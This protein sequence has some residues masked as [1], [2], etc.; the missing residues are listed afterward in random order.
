MTTLSAERPILLWIGRFFAHDGYG[1]AARLHRAAVRE[2]GA[3]VVAVDIVSR[4]IVGSLPDGLVDVRVTPNGLTVRATDHRRPIVA[5]VHDRPDQYRRVVAAGRSQ[6]I[7]YSYWETTSVPPN[8]AAWMTSMDRIWVSSQFNADAFASA[9]VPSWMIDRVGHPI[10]HLACDVAM[11]R[12]ALRARWPESTVFLSI[13]S[14]AVGRRDTNLLFEAFAMAFDQDDDVALV[15]KVPEKGLEAVGVSLEQVMLSMAARSSGRWPNVYTI[16]AVLTREQLLRLHASV[17]CY[18]SCERGNGWD[19]P[20]FD[21]MTMGIPV[22]AANFGASTTFVDPVDSYVV[23]VSTRFTACDAAF[24]ERHSLYSGQYWPYVDPAAMAAELR[25]VHDAP[26]DRAKRGAAAA[27]R[28]THDYDPAAVA[29]EV[30]ALTSTARESDLRANTPAVVTISQNDDAWGRTTGGPT[31]ATNSRLQEAALAG[32]LS[33]QDF[34]HPR[35]PKD[36]WRAYKRATT[37]AQRHGKTLEGSALKTALSRP[38]SVPMTRPAHKLSAIVRARSAVA[39]ALTKLGDPEDLRDVAALVQNYEAVLGGA[40]SSLTPE[41]LEAMWVEVERYGLTR[42]PDADLARLRELRDRHSGRVFILGNGPSLLRCDLSRLADEYTFGVNKIYLL[43]DQISWRPTYYTLLDRKMGAAVGADI[44]QLDGTVK[45]VPERF[46]GVFP[47]GPSTYWYWTRPVGA[48]IDDQFEPDISLGIPSRATVLVTAIQQAFYLGFRTIILI[49]V[50]A[51]YTIPE[52]V[53]QS[54]PDRFGTGT[55]LH[56]TST[57]DD[58]PNHFS[59]AY[60]GKGSRWHDPNVAEMHRMFRIMRKGVE[61]HGGRLLN[62]T[63]GGSLEVL[64]RVDYDDLF[65]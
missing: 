27:Q 13:V 28:I 57:A 44:G 33:D 62:A 55:R 17:D 61:R 19:L 9:G 49:G 32:L 50:D 56:L 3:P 2:A 52:T 29:A 24:N 7:G 16:P 48:H 41:Q 60:F 30:M 51:A 34:A 40:Q 63:D 38:M 65:S 45:F 54:G 18:V 1:T 53:E 26:E 6:L 59:P 20:A 10:D 5:V 36:F 11:S 12:D 14:S 46:R 39:G 47:G 58:D 8:W 22:V 23:D 42:S 35:R 31:V 15:L 25:R 64:E 37:H 4:S 21:S 43:F